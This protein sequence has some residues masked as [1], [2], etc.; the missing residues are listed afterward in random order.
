MAGAEQE[1]QAAGIVESTLSRYTGNAFGQ[2]GETD[3]KEFL[4]QKR[5]Y[6]FG[7]GDQNS[8]FFISL[9]RMFHKG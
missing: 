1:I 6:P 5:G 2:H 9:L 3:L 7:T 4:L 8:V